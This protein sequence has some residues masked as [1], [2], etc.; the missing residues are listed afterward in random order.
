M[1]NYKILALT[2]HFI[3]LLNIILE[4]LIGFFFYDTSQDLELLS[5][6]MKCNS[7]PALLRCCVV[8]HSQDGLKPVTKPRQVLKS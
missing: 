3:G 1:Y 5:S 6:Q 8:L 7:S 2:K 4:K